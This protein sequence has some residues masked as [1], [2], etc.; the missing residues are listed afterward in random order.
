MKKYNLWFLSLLVG[1][2]IGGVTG[3]LV[4]FYNYG[5][6]QVAEIRY[7][8]PFLFIPFLFVSGTLITFLFRRFGT[9][10]QGSMGYVLSV[11]DSEKKDIP[12]R[13]IPLVIGTTWLTQLFGGSTGRIGGAIEIGAAVSSQF[14]RRLA[15]KYNWEKLK[16]IFLLS[17]MVAGFSAVFQTPIAAVFFMFE[18]DPKRQ[19]SVKSV[20]PAVLASFSAQWT[21]SLFGAEKFTADLPGFD[22]INLSALAKIIILGILFGIVGGLFSASVS[23]LTV[24]LRRLLTNIYLRVIAVSLLL[25]V[26]V[27]AFHQGRYA[28]LSLSLIRDSFNGGQIYA[29]DW[30]AKLVLSALTLSVGY[31]GGVATPIFV[32][33]AT[34]GAF[35]GCLLG[36]PIVVC[37]S[38]G[39]VAVFASATNTWIAPIVIGIEAFGFDYFL[40]FLLVCVIAYFI[41][42]NRSVFFPFKRIGGRKNGS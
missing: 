31:Q 37:A 3:C 4:A 27:L 25:S 24:I 16:E 34:F 19:N 21:A 22:W 35:C 36:L 1:I 2:L 10:L 33:G 17:G 6:L 12:L 11:K 14:D 5:L 29:Y 38:L 13:L 41:N 26:C 40:V 9:E 18:L 39:Y 7:N 28:G 32:I 8:F 15:G 20:I 30:L 23:T 42:G